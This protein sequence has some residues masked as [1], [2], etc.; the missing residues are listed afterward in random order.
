MT[1]ARN[2]PFPADPDPD[3]WRIEPPRP[4]SGAEPPDEPAMDELE[5]CSLLSC[6]DALGRLLRR[7]FF[8]LAIALVLP[9]AAP[10]HGP[11]PPAHVF[12]DGHDIDGP[13]PGPEHV[14]M[15]LGLSIWPTGVS[16]KIRAERTA[17]AATESGVESAVGINASVFAHHGYY[18]AQLDVFQLEEATTD[19]FVLGG[20]AFA[21]GAALSQ[22]TVAAR[23]SREIFRFDT[24]W[25]HYHLDFGFRYTLAAVTFEG[26]TLQ[27]ARNSGFLSPELILHSITVLDE[28]SAF[29][30]RTS[31]AT[32]GATTG[33]ETAV[34]FSAGLN[35]R[36]FETPWSVHDISIGVRGL[37]SKLGFTDQGTGQ[38][39]T[40]TNVYLGPELGYACRW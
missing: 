23:A 15:H 26:G 39:T 13:P 4:E 7:G 6:F 1:T 37:T 36:L 40:I 31:I 30:S 29:H 20:T 34:E 16:T 32:N 17:R 33:R 5:D 21:P 8:V 22:L 38:E 25:A 27:Q 9:S 35:Y 14:P 28:R 19:P 24:S 18:S 3:F 2:K 12:I 10:A 11:G